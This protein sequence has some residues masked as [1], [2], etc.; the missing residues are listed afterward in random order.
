MAGT[1]ETDMLGRWTDC[2][3]FTWS[4]LKTVR[5]Q[6]KNIVCFLHATIICDKSQQEINWHKKYLNACYYYIEYTSMFGD[7]M[8]MIDSIQWQ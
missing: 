1:H 4:L 8:E 7:W 3:K 6:P 2:C 5:N